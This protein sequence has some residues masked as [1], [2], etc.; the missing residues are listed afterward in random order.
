MARVP[1]LDPA[2]MTPQQ[3]RI[4][5]DIA[6][7]RGGTV[8]GPFAIWLRT[9]EIADRANQFGNVVRANGKIDKR[10]FELMVLIVARHWS[11]P[12]EW[13]AHEKHAVSA[14]VSSDVIEAIR[15][16]RT[17]DFARDDE[18]LVYDIVSELNIS[19]D[20]SQPCYDR[21]VAHFGL[22]LF[23]EFVTAIGFY[24]MVAVVLKAFDAPVPGG[25]RP[26]P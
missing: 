22:E 8:R 21:G 14:G 23:I 2:E 6:A 7:K 4:H 15:H 26:L 19:R 3:K 18:K 16:G 5:D 11:A 10:L 13:F 25:S 24:I 20:L 12:Y 17:P 1:D 9:P